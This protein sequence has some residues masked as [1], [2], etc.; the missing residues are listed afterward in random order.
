MRVESAVEHS[1]SYTGQS[2]DLA[3]YLARSKAVEIS[4]LDFERARAHPVSPAELRCLGYMM[5]IEAHTLCYMRDVVN[6]GAGADPEI[7]DFL[8]CWVY[9]ESY[10]GRAIEKFVR[11]M[12][13][14][15]PAA[16]CGQ[17]VPT[18][19]E[20]LE[21]VGARLF[22]ALYGPGFLTVHMTWG[23]IQEHTTLY[24]YASLAKRT[25]NP[26]LAELLRRI[27]RDESRHFGFYYYK[28]FQG[29]K[30]DPGRQRLV[31]FF[32]KRFWTPVGE[33]VKPA[34]E[35]DFLLRTLF[36]GE[37]GRDSVARIDRTMSRLPGLGWFDLMS[38][39][40][41][42]AFGRAG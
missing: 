28:A 42:A 14:E 9:E 19:S 2:F 41:E 15:R 30:D 3:G 40:A 35:T 17:H 36:D 33:G 23:A 5:D 4:D 24:G 21:N 12:G 7:A 27:A 11:A 20:R 26:V 22:G 38:R 39:R 18:L 13:V 6:A 10:H 37:D 29:L 32:L 1:E 34:S 31:S 25:R 16:V 8:A